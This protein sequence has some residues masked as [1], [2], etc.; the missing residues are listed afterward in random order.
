MFRVEKQF[1]FDAILWTGLGANGCWRLPPQH[2]VLSQFSQLPVSHAM[3]NF[4]RQRSG[5]HA[6]ASNP[7]NHYTTISTTCA[8]IQSIRIITARPL[9]T[10]RRPPVRFGQLSRARPLMYAHTLGAALG[11]S[12]TCACSANRENERHARVAEFNHPPQNF[13]LSSAK[14]NRTHTHCAPQQSSWLARVCVCEC[15]SIIH[16]HAHARSLALTAI[17]RRCRRKMLGAHKFAPR[18]K[19]ENCAAAWPVPGP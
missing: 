11:R 14:S 1:T 17:H 3:R 10:R 9:R 2:I 15:G 19:A 16:M 4:L 5:R 7:S 12:G 8:Q 13:C 18:I 6:N